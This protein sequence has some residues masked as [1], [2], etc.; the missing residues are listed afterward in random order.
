[1]TFTR[2]A[3][4]RVAALAALACAAGAAQATITVSTSLSSFTTAAGGVVSTD[5]FSDLTINTYL[6][7]LS[8]SRTAGSFGYSVTS[9][10][11]STDPN[12]FPSDLFVA[13]AAGTV[14]LSTAWF[15]DTLT[16]GNFA[17]TV[18]SVG[19]NLFGTSTGAAYGELT[20]LA[21]TIKATDKNGL[22]VT[23]TSTGNSLSS[24]VGFTSDV[25]LDSI[26]ISAT[27][28]NTGA[29][30][31]IDNV[32]LS[33]VPEPSSWLLML[34]GGAAVLSLAKRRRA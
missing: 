26:V 13:P 5:K 27:T 28:P 18:R 6:G 12:N 34:A 3:L 17:P 4:F 30:V 33:A 31:T 21:L 29:T 19:T 1:M 23:T 15:S 14:A 22:T 2:P 7:S 20:G 8:T 11:L 24:F 9:S 16:L 10:N 25:P 32:V